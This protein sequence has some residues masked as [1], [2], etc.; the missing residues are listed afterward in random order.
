MAYVVGSTHIP[1]EATKTCNCRPSVINFCPRTPDLSTTMEIKPLAVTMKD[2]KS[3]TNIFSS[4]NVGST[5]KHARKK[6]KTA[7]WVS[8]RSHM[9]LWEHANVRA[10]GN[11]S[12]PQTDTS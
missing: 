1:Q 10:A 3:L 9:H 6:A 7:K 12:R 5:K 4:F 2:M 8:R 11:H